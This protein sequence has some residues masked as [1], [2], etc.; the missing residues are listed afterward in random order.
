MRFSWKFSLFAIALPLL[1]FSNPDIAASQPPMEKTLLWQISGP[2]LSRPSYLYGTVHLACKDQTFLSENLRKSFGSVSQLYLELDHDDPTLTAQT[3]QSLPMRNGQNL[4][5]LLTQKDYAQADQFFQKNL[6]IPLDRVNRVKPLFLTTMIAPLFMGCQ[7]TSWEKTFADMASSRKI[8]ILGLETVQQQMA[9]IDAIPLKEQAS[10]LMDIV[11]D[12]FKARQETNALFTAYKNQDIAK[13][14]QITAQSPGMTPRYIT[15]L[16]SDRNQRWIPKIL[17]AA[18]A[19]PTFF[20]VGA[21]HLAGDRGVIS[22]L[23]KAGYTV[24]PLPANSAK[25][26]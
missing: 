21:A 3:F 18:K 22:L 14:Y 13:L 24:K 2:G 10:A 20:G 8:E 9:A 23:R 11:R 25:K 6:K 5:T 17:K 7:P 12:P 26:P 15:L 16:L 4:R 19:K 1:S